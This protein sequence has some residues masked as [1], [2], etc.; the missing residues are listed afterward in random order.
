[1][2][3]INVQI[4]RNNFVQHTLYEVIRAVEQVQNKAVEWVL[5]LNQAGGPLNKIALKIQDIVKWLE[6][7]TGQRFFDALTAGAIVATTI[8]CFLAD[9]V[10]WIVSLFVDNWSFISPIIWGIAAA[11]RNN[12]V[13][14]TLYE[15]I[16]YT[17]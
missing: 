16:R 13:Q 17:Q 7:P 15:V 1:M 9:I 2:A 3:D 6:S 8:A 4:K 5:S 14:H 10:L 11:M 12:F